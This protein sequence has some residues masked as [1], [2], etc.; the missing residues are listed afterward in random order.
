MTVSVNY[1]HPLIFLR[2]PLLV[3]LVGLKNVLKLE[4]NI[5]TFFNS[6]NDE[7]DVVI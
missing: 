1:L 3:E 6:S 7:Y 5:S 2:K 4:W